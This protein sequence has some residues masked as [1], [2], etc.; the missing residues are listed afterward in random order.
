MR[1]V[2]SASQQTEYKFRGRLE[3][4]QFRKCSACGKSEGHNLRTCEDR[5][6]MEGEITHLI[7]A[8][9]DWGAEGF[10]ILR[11]W[12]DDP[13]FGKVSIPFLVMLQWADMH[14]IGAFTCV[15]RHVFNDG[16]VTYINWELKTREGDNGEIIKVLTFRER[17]YFSPNWYD[18]WHLTGDNWDMLTLNSWEAH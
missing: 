15:E 16:D 8:A 14:R 2:I 18:P 11:V 7:G 1:Q 17:D 4:G 5:R 9:G 3:S 12:L 10:C 13:T 6:L